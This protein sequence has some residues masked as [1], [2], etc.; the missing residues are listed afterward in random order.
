MAAALFLGL[1]VFNK[2]DLLV[3]VAATEMPRFP[4]YNGHLPALPPRPAVSIWPIHP[5][6]SLFYYDVS[7]LKELESRDEA[8]DIEAH[9]DRQGQVIFYTVQFRE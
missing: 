4:R 8:V 6:W 9:S 2:I 7:Y 5:E 1:G 3:F